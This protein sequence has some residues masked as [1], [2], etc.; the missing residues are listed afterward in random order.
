MPHY[1]E[2][3]A[4]SSVNRVIF[5]ELPRYVHNIL[6]YSVDKSRMYFRGTDGNSTFSTETG[7]RIELSQALTSTEESSLDTVMKVEGSKAQSGAITSIGTF[8]GEYPNCQHILRVSPS[9]S[10][11]ICSNRLVNMFLSLPRSICTFL[12]TMFFSYI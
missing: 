6:G 4:V 5:S 12:N 2:S 3:I 7:E 10:G 9:I 1:H 8:E 11:R